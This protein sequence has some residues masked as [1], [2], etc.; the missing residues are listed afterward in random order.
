MHFEKYTKSA[1]GQLL[2]HY[3]R[4]NGEER[5]YSNEDIDKTKSHENYNLA[6]DRGMDEITYMNERL[7]GVKVFNRKDVVYMVDLIVTMPKDYKGDREAF[8]RESYD[9]ACSKF[10]GEKNII[11]AWV[12]LDEKSPH[13]HMAGMPIVQTVD[14]QGREIEKLCCNDF[15]TRQFLKEFHPY[16]EKGLSERL[17]EP[18]HMLNEATREGNKSVKEL[19]QETAIKEVARLNH[20]IEEHRDRLDLTRT[21]LETVDKELTEKRRQ[22]EDISKQ[23]YKLPEPRKML[24]WTYYPPQAVQGFIDHAAE[25]ERHAA[26]R[27]DKAERDRDQIQSIAQDEHARAD[28]LQVML[29]RLNA[30]QWDREYIAHQLDEIDRVEKNQERDQEHTRTHSH[31]IDR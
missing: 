30:K 26:E 12:H 6:P 28:R 2:K 13:M 31:D 11:S 17:H 19:K 4:N 23:P 5:N 25:R 16:M 3:N 14:K 21:T 15:L 27:A 7:E 29:D 8:F 1:V 22:L 10:G 24:F 18:V 20:E 9:L